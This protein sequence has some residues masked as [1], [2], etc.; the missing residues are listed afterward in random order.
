VT[1]RVSSDFRRDFARLPE[2]VKKQAREAYRL[3]KANPNHPGLKFKKLPPH[4]DLWSVRISG[5]YRAVGRWRGDVVLWFFIGS[6]A[7][8]D[9]LLARL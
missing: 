4:E 9:N 1:S 6:H 8:Y 2:R 7:D 3:F 5:E